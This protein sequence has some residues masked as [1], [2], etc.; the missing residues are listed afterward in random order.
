MRYGLQRDSIEIRL[1]MAL[2]RLL[3]LS[4]YEYR[5]RIQ[6][7]WHIDDNDAKEVSRKRVKLPFLVIAIR[8][9]IYHIS[10]T[11]FDLID[12][13]W[14]KFRTIFNLAHH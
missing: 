1:L 12:K 4:Y 8:G 10:S 5:N 7:F 3:R 13:N 11:P 2:G 9:H 14:H 6:Y